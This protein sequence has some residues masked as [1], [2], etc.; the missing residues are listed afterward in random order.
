[1][2]KITVTPDCKNA[3]RKQFLKDFNI[4][5]ATG[6]ADFIIRHVNDDIRWNIYGDKHIEGKDHFVKEMNIMKDY[7]A[8]EVVI[9]SIITHGREAAVNGEMKM[10][11]KTYAFCDV[12]RFTNTTSETI[13][14]MDSYV[15][16]IT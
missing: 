12:Y 7:T 3:P 6:D 11:G 13:R 14:Q 10:A 8:D 9:H 5:F 1:M 2:T 16:P 15:L 4:A